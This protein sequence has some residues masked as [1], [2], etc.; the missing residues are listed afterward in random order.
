MSNTGCTSVNKEKKHRVN[1]MVLMG[2]S[3]KQLLDS[4]AFHIQMRVFT[5]VQIMC[6]ILT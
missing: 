2:F 3:I 4:N 5:C 1:E 6:F